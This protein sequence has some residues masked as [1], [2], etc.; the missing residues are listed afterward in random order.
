MKNRTNYREAV[1]HLKK[2]RTIYKK[3][4]RLEDFERFMAE[5]MKKT[6]RLRAF[7]EECKRGKLIDV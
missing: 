1:R 5:L 6:K 3:M 2:L 7:Q 4:K